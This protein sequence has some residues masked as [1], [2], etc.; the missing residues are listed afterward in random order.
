MEVIE[1]FRK[2]GT[3]SNKR[4]NNNNPFYYGVASFAKRLQKSETQTQHPMKYE[5]KNP[6]RANLM[7]GK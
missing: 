3:K 2:S 5:V 4:K 1:E 7:R 6:L